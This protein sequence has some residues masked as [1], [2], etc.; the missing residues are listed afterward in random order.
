[1]LSDF[2]LRFSS[3]KVTL[4]EVF[5]VRRVNGPVMSF[6]ICTPPR[7]NKAIIKRQ[8]VS[9][10]VA[11]ARS[12]APEVRVVIEDVLINVGQDELLVG[13]AVNGHRNQADIAVLWLGFFGLEHSV[14]E[15]G[16]R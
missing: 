1:M 9:D 15:E 3:S 11:P 2:S 5:N 14:V 8:I 6:A 16:H 4:L 13:V 7:L 12:A 10:R